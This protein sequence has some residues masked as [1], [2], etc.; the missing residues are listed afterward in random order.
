MAFAYTV[1]PHFEFYDTT[2]MMAFAPLQQA[3][4][5][6]DWLFLAGYAFGMTGLFLGGAWLAFRRKRF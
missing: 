6:G 1:V 4:G 3:L 5:L 2:Q